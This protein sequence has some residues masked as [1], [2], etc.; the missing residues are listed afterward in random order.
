[1]R[2]IQILCLLFLATNIFGQ[3]ISRLEIEE[4]GIYPVRNDTVIIDTLIMHDHATL[5]LMSS[6][7]HLIVDYLIRGDFCE[8]NA[9]GDK[10]RDGFPGADGKHFAPDNDGG[11][12]GFGYRG[13]KGKLKMLWINKLDLLADTLDRD[14]RLRVYYRGGEGGNGGRGGNGGDRTF[15]C[16]EAVPNRARWGRGGGG[17]RGGEETFPTLIFGNEIDKRSVNLNGK[18]GPNGSSAYSGEEGDIIIPDCPGDTTEYVISPPLPPLEPKRPLMSSAPISGKIT[19]ANFPY[20]PPSPSAMIS[21]LPVS[22]GDTLLGKVDERLQNALK[23]C[24][25]ENRRYFKFP[26]GYAVVSGMEQIS[27]AGVPLEGKERWSEQASFVQKFSLK[28][29]LRSLFSARTGYFRLI[30]FIVSSDELPTKAT[31]I[32]RTEALDWF[33][34]GWTKLPRQIAKQPFTE[35]HYVS[36]LIYEFS[37][38]ENA[39]GAVFSEPSLISAEQ[40]LRGAKLWPLLIA[41]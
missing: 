21:N 23:A 7:V 40:H 14:N 34:S 20:P 10:G 33:K 13:G 39:D 32:S 1:M 28:T 37:V 12:G 30:V 17:G 26:E 3:K 9:D 35:D 22:R 19:A 15:A 41:E 8:I 4:H 27:E 11:D 31:P 38:S 36:A 16:G 6:G 5:K 29:Y 24:G 18:K 2:P 25:Y